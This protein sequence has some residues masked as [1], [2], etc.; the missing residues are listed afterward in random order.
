VVVVPPARPDPPIQPDDVSKRVR[1]A[2]ALLAQAIDRLGDARDLLDEAAQVE[3]LP[4][5][6]AGWFQAYEGVV[7]ALRQNLNAASTWNDDK[8]ELLFSRH[9][10]LDRRRRPSD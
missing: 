1:E 2:T 5:G 3:S 7:E 8:A 9:S 10:P 6:L 4:D